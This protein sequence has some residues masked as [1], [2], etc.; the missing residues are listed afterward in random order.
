MGNSIILHN[1]LEKVNIHVHACMYIPGPLGISWSA[2]LGPSVLS[3]EEHPS[4]CVTA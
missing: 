3:F 1:I 2:V 4:F